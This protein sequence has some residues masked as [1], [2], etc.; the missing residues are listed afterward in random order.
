M[1]L[2]H[3]TRRKKREKAQT[4]GGIDDLSV[5]MPEDIGESYVPD[6]EQPAEPDYYGDDQADLGY[7]EEPSWDEED[8]LPDA[9]TNDEADGP[10]EQDEAADAGNG[11]DRDVVPNTGARNRDDSGVKYD[12]RNIRGGRRERPP[13]IQEEP[14]ARDGTRE[15]RP[16]DEKSKY[17]AFTAA[18]G[19]A[20]ALGV[21]AIGFGTYSIVNNFS[22]GP[23]SG[24]AMPDTGGTQQNVYYD[25]AGRTHV[26]IYI[27]K[28]D[29]K[30][31][32]VYIDKDGNVTFDNGEDKEPGNEQT[33]TPETPGGETGEPGGEATT[34]ETPGQPGD[35]GQEQATTPDTAEPGES[36]TESQ[37]PGDS[38]HQKVTPEQE[39]QLLDAMRERIAQ[40]GSGYQESD[41]VYIVKWRDT[42]TKIS[43]M[44]GFSVDFLAEYNHIADRNLIITGESIRYPSFTSIGSP[45]SSP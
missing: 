34:P 38:L 11:A 41:E 25:S 10:G 26:N 28:G 12:A 6:D 31:V 29:E 44:T 16:M 45:A 19:L 8:S 15:R 7:A 32:N 39:K 17:R 42:L 22:L 9:P 35:T 24:Y 27:T 37:N 20:C 43:N 5:S 4:R 40:G 18:C 23:E 14:R 13:R 2:F 21:A 1:F 30:E 33:A 36:G 3:R